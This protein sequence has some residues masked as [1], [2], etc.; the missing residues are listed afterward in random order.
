MK[1]ETVGERDTKAVMRFQDDP[2]GV[3]LN[4]TNWGFCE[5]QFGVESNDW[6]SR[7]RRT[8]HEC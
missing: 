3:V 2:R 7:Q 4:A 1:M 6:A 8:I 5:D